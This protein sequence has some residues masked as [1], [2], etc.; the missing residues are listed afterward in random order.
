MKGF[1]YTARVILP[2]DLK[3][4]STMDLSLLR[5]VLTGPWQYLTEWSLLL[6]DGKTV[7]QQSSDTYPMYIAPCVHAGRHQRLVIMPMQ[8][9]KSRRYF[10]VQEKEVQDV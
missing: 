1:N 10:Y 5:M 3:Q 8:P 4:P 9:T 7:K 6:P 2:D